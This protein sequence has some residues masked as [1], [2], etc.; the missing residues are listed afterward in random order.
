MSKPTTTTAARKVA[1][2]T[3]T[4]LVASTSAPSGRFRRSDL[5]FGREKRFWPLD[6]LRAT[7]GASF[8][9]KLDAVLKEP[10]VVAKLCSA[11]EAAEEAR[12]A[13][14]P[15]ELEVS[16]AQLAARVAELEGRLAVLE[17]PKG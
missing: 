16:N 15:A 14:D 3:A 11:E 4:H 7:W 2:A 5:Q 6:E 17:A 8:E 9:A 12:P 1:P 13:R 10:L